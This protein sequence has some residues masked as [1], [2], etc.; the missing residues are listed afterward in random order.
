M[1]GNCKKVVP[2]RRI[3]NEILMRRE[4]KQRLSESRAKRWSSESRSKLVCILP[5]RDRVRET[6][7]VWAL[8]SVSC[9]DRRS[10]NVNGAKIM[11][12][13]LGHS[14][15][16]ATLSLSLSGANR[17]SYFIKSA[18]ACV[19]IRLFLG[20]CKGRLLFLLN[21]K[22]AASQQNNNMDE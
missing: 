8:P 9:F 6:Q 21:T 22:A 12:D 1:T 17:Q 5:S 19:N 11:T 13:S 3:F 18:P 7:I 15:I 2:L 20:R 14:N 4:L 16:F 10:N